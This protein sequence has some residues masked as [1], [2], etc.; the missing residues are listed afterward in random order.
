MS[1]S[2]ETPTDERF[3][4]RDY[5]LSI[6]GTWQTASMAYEADGTM[7]PE[8][9]VQFTHAGILYGH[10]KDGE[11]VFDHSDRIICFERT[12]AGGFKVQALSSGGVQYTYRSSES[13]A[14]VLEYYET[15]EEA[16]FPDR[17]RGGA[18]LSRSS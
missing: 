16:A 18:S 4:A 7:Q 15:W 8:Y 6:P 1:F 17:Y 10:W 14:D 13:V 9:Y 2:E 3:N 5:L 11:F 12:A